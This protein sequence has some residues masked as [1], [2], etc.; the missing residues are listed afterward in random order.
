MTPKEAENAVLGKW[1]EAYCERR[2]DSYIIRRPRTSDDR[3]SVLV[4]VTLG[5]NSWQDSQAAAWLDA[6]TRIEQD[7][8]K[9]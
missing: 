1:P 5:V 8:S 3:P 2:G 9:L 7:G 4:F 6:A